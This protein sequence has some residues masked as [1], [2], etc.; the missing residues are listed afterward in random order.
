MRRVCALLG[1]LSVLVASSGAQG[2]AASQAR[3]QPQRVASPTDDI[4]SKSALIT[5]YC[6]TCHNERTKAGGLM[7]DKMDMTR[8]GVGS[9]PSERR[10]E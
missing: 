8:M 3:L 2:T 4:A 6:V 7:L 10:C 5:K 9:E 1:G